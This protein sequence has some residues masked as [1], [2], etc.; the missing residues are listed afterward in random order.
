MSQVLSLPYGSVYLCD[1]IWTCVW[2]VVDQLILL[3]AGL[4]PGWV[5]W[6]T[7]CLGQVGLTRFIRYLGL[8]RILHCITLRWWCLTLV[9]WRWKCIS[10][11]VLNLVI[12][13]D[14]ILKKKKDTKGSRAWQQFWIVFN[15][16]NNEEVFGVAC[17][18]VCKAY[19]TE[20][21]WAV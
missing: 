20:R 7:F 5:I 8:T 18:H 19:F 12:D 10:Q 2:F 1:C 3:N 17:C 15:P 21:K 13:G 4:K 9:W 6:V 16:I 11:D 14:Y